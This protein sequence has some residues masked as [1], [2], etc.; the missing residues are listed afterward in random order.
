M[1][2]I[3]S[4]G[5][6]CM[7]FPFCNIICYTNEM[8]F[9]IVYL[10]WINNTIYFSSL[11]L[12]KIHQ[13]S[14]HFQKM[15]QIHTSEITFCMRKTSSVRITTVNLF[16]WRTIQ[17]PKSSSQLSFSWTRSGTQI[18][19]HYYDSVETGENSDCVIDFSHTFCIFIAIS[20]K[21]TGEKNAKKWMLWMSHVALKGIKL[22]YFCGLLNPTIWFI[23]CYL[24]CRLFTGVNEGWVSF[25]NSPELERTVGII[26]NTRSPTMLFLT[27]ETELH[28][29]HFQQWVDSLF[30][31]ILFSA[32]VSC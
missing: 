8:H 25:H 2:P 1:I 12:W 26:S 23:S 20:P 29:S 28:F 11:Y 32:S 17:L 21:F 19:S 24:F 15:K 10:F 13:Y 22:P 7:L 27:V 5:L 18:R 31:L 4:H 16:T 30:W 6:F 14:D 3:D 9:I